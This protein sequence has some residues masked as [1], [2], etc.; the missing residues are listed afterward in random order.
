MKEWLRKQSLAT[1][2]ALV[3][4]CLIPVVYKELLGGFSFA[5]IL[6]SVLYVLP[7]CFLLESVRKK[8]LF[9]MLSSYS[10]CDMA[11]ITI[12]PSY[13]KPEWSVFSPKLKPHERRLLVPDGKNYIVVR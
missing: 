9:V 6:S 4:I 7:L 10:V 11:D 3:V 13:A 1:V 12:A 5:R 8:W 2:L